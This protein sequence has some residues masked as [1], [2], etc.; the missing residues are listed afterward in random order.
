[1]AFGVSFLAA[2][3]PVRNSDAYN[4]Y[5]SIDP[6]GSVAEL[7]GQL[8]YYAL[9]MAA[10]GIQMAGPDLTPDNLK[11]GLSRYPG[12]TG[13]AGSWLFPPENPYTPNIDGRIVWWDPKAI[14]NYNGQPG[15]YLD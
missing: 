14:S 3:Q 11:L 9:E 1:H 15:S 7:S 2:Q 5:K 6:T 12:G 4:A 10:I 13:Q 8:I